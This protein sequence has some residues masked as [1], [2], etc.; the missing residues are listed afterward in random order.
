MQITAMSNSNLCY[1]RIPEEQTNV[2][3]AD[4]TSLAKQAHPRTLRALN[5]VEENKSSVEGWKRKDAEPQGVAQT[6]KTERRVPE[7]LRS[8]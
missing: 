8:N 7:M 6:G 5:K 2:H 1:R 3:N 4:S